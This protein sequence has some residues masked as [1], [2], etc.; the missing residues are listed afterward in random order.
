VDSRDEEIFT[1]I[2]LEHDKL[3][4]CIKDDTLGDYLSD[5]FSDA[6]RKVVA[7]IDEE[8][9]LGNLPPVEPPSD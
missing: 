1:V 8:I 6:M 5:V 3:V 2:K 7:Y 9:E 4:A